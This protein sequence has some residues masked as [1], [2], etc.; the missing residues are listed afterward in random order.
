MVLRPYRARD[1]RRMAQFAEFSFRGNPPK[2]FSGF[3]SL[4]GSSERRWR[5]N[6]FRPT[7]GPPA[8]HRPQGA[9]ERFLPAFGGLATHSSSETPWAAFTLAEGCPSNDG[10]QLRFV[11]AQLKKKAMTR[12]ELADISEQSM[13]AAA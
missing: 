7:E 6:R 10:M 13:M 5:W 9:F 8:E 12:H 2:S 1:L 3:L 4:P 11:I